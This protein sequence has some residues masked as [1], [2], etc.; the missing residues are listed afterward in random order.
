M[1]YSKIELI[2]LI[3][4]ENRVNC[5]K[6]YTDCFNGKKF[7]EFERAVTE[8]SL[9]I[10]VCRWLES[11]PDLQDNTVWDQ[12]SKAADRWLETSLE[13]RKI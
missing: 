7:D 3:F 6:S 2:V 10:L 11:T 8:P 1:F 5:F 13:V 9:L 12:Y 4:K